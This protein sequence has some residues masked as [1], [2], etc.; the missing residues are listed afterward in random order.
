[1]SGIGCESMGKGV[2]EFDDSG[3]KVYVKSGNERI[4]EREAK[5]DMLEDLVEDWFT[6]LSLSDK[7][8]HHP[9]GKGRLD[10]VD[11]GWKDENAEIECKNLDPNNGYKWS[12]SVIKT[13][14]TRRSKAMFR[15]A[16]ITCKKWG[17]TG[18]QHLECEGWRVIE[19]GAIET[20][21][22]RKEAQ[23]RFND[24][25]VDFI[26]AKCEFKESLRA[27]GIGG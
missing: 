2:Y 19:I 13:E 14:I 17:K 18:D 8:I 3:E 9:H 4:P 27:L 7:I 1:M 16:I 12:T 22:E 11:F 21:D 5:G 10:K 20:K 25:I 23:K 6:E 15:I 24:G 26:I